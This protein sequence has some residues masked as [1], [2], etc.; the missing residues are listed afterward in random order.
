MSFVYLLASNPYR[1]L[2]CGSTTDL[3]R[4]VWEHRSKSVP[5]FTARYG[6]DRLVW[7]EVHDLL[8]TARSIGARSGSKVRKQ[9][10]ICVLRTVYE[11]AVIRRE[12]V[13]V[14]KY[15]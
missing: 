5:G 6:V 13:C 1:T 7:Y 10:P 12:G 2:Y 3:L 8:E 14:R 15:K 11:N 4:R 9:L